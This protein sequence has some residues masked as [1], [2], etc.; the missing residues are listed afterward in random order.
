MSEVTIIIPNFN[1]KAYISDCLK[2]LEKQ[3]FQDFEIILV[4]ND[5]KDGSRELVEQEFP[6][7]KIIRLSQNFGFSRA[8]NE[9]IKASDSPYILLLNNDIK[10]DEYFVEELYHSICQ[11]PRIFSAA[12]KMLQMRH[13]DQIDGAGDLYCALGWGFAIG[14]GKNK[15]HYQKETEVFAACAGAAIYRKAILMNIILHIL[16]M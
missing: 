3:S 14:K 11:N 6:S 12:A 15:S 4:D 7:V 1:G 5:S 10:A 13:P 9:G 8:A 2:S 16:R